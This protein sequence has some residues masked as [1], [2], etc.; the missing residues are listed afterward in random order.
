MTQKPHS[1]TIGLNE[2]ASAV[3]KAVGRAVKAKEAI[4]P[5]KQREGHGL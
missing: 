4:R 2:L 1:P 5:G 3:D